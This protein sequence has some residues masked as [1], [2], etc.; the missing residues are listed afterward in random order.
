MEGPKG[1]KVRWLNIRFTRNQL[2][3]GLLIVKSFIKLNCSSFHFRVTSED[4]GQRSNSHLWS[5]KSIYSLL[6]IE[7]MHKGNGKSLQIV[8]IEQMEQKSWF[9][10]I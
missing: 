2:L 4:Q 1:D 10:F 9:F 8:F 5:S 7:C 6:C 3:M